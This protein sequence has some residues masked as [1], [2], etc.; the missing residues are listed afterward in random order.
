M[1]EPPTIHVGRTVA[2]TPFATTPFAPP[3]DHGRV[4]PTD[5]EE[6]PPFP[7]EEHPR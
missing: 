3:S 7:G 5:R 4:L 6:T 1:T 2:D